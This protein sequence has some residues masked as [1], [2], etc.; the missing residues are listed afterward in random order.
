MFL[1]EDLNGQ[2]TSPAF[3]GED[4]TCQ[5]Q[6]I[7]NINSGIGAGNVVVVT[8]QWVDQNNAPISPPLNWFVFQ[9]SIN[10]TSTAILY[11]YHRDGSFVT[12]FDGTCHDAADVCQ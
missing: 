5:G 9:V 7:S 1:I 12:D 3:A 11:V 10:K 6:S 2:A 4:F 8:A